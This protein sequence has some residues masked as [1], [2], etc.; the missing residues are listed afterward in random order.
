MT[1]EPPAERQADR[2][3]GGDGRFTRSLETADRDAKAARLRSRGMSYRQIA[4]ELGVEV[5]SA[6][7]AVQRA[8][9]DALGEAPADVRRLELERLDQMEAA[10]WAVL[11][12]D[13]ITVSQG[14]VVRRR[15]LDDNGDPIVAG[16][17]RD[18]KPVFR[19]EDVLD[20]GPVLQAVDRL[21]KIQARRAA[22]LGL[23]APVKAET[24]V[25]LNYTIVGV[26]MGQL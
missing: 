1:D 12:R 24:G 3:R 9:K 2:T 18:D 22:L 25:T 14:R 13:H 5:A 4:A 11:E 17:D 10:V 16:R 19:E 7:D 26:D 23:D 8:L 21:L 20:D 6:Y 15:I